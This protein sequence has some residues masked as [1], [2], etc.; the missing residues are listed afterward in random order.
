M[1]V[2]VTGTSRGRPVGVNGRASILEAGRGVER[3]DAAVEVH[4]QLVGTGRTV[5]AAPA[6]CARPAQAEVRNMV[7]FI[8]IF[9]FILRNWEDYA[10]HFGSI[11][12]IF[13]FFMPKREKLRLSLYDLLTQLP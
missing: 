10:H 2:T 1:A 9:R 7:K 4:G 8:I 12:T 6:G 3:D 5:D 11:D 13:S